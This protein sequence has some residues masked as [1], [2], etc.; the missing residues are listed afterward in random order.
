MSKNISAKAL[1]KDA[2]ET[3]SCTLIPLSKATSVERKLKSLLISRMLLSIMA[4][5]YN[6][7]PLFPSKVGQEQEKIIYI[8]AS[9]AW[10]EANL[11]PSLIQ[12]LNRPKN[13]KL[14]TYYNRLKQ[15]LAKLDPV[16]GQEGGRKHRR[17]RRKQKGGL[18]A[19]VYIIGTV[20]AVLGGQAVLPQIGSWWR[21]WNDQRAA[22]A[23]EARERAKIKLEEAKHNQTI[24]RDEQR[25]RDAAAARERQAQATERLAEATENA[26]TTNAN[27]LRDAAEMSAA[28]S[29]VSTRME[30]QGQAVAGSNTALSE[31][32]KELAALGKVIREEKRA[33]KGDPTTFAQLQ[34]QAEVEE[35]TREAR[36][37][38]NL[39]RRCMANVDEDYEEALRD[40]RALVDW[41]LGRVQAATAAATDNDLAIGDTIISFGVAGRSAPPSHQI[42]PPGT[43]GS[44]GSCL[45][46]P[47][48][49]GYKRKYRKRRRKTKRRRRKKRK[50]RR[51]KRKT[52]RRRRRT[53]RR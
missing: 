42:C 25:A 6:D 48:A 9:V 2:M 39:A 14:K 36:D 7:S 15:Q 5:D 19:T 30:T 29:I 18:A 13:S 22:A 35:N 4:V 52:R 26:A 51:R 11:K 8:T 34:V 31:A 10:L 32:H 3:I 38:L 27:A 44:H 50:T 12:L 24:A 43:V 21:N 17:R 16:V 20:I 1:Y 46:D 41:Q 49:G 33:C 45:Q 53:R 40:A 37:A 28:A 23:E 47:N